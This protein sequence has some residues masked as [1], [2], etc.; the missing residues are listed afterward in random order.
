MVQ[1]RPARWVLNRYH[2]TSSVTYML[3]LA[4]KHYN[5]VKMPVWSY[6]IKYF[7]DWLL[8]VHPNTQ[9]PS[10]GP[11]DTITSIVMYKSR[12]KPSHT[13]TRFFPPHHR[14]MECST[15]ER[16][17]IRYS[18]LIQEPPG[19][20]PW[21]PYLTLSNICTYCT[22]IFLCCIFSTYSLF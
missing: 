1:R 9:L 19:S 15:T 4:G 21:P 5:S 3:P 20:L 8:S 16:R 11:P 2:N 12:R 7:T 22:F 14:P 13:Y 18:R 17:S 6:F 10:T